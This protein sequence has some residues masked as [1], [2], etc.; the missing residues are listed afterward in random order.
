MSLFGSSATGHVLIRIS[1]TSRSGLVDLF[2]KSDETSDTAT[3]RVGHLQD[4]FDATLK[5][6]SFAEHAVATAAAAH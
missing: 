3:T 4:T 5:A 2:I 1:L 6:G